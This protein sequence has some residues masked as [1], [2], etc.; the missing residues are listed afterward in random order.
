MEKTKKR[1][2]VV[3]KVVK[4]IVLVV[5][6]LLAAFVVVNV[7]LI[8]KSYINPNK[9]PDFFGFKPFIVLSGSMEPEI[10]AGDLVLTKT[11][12]P[13]EIKV[14]DVISFQAEDNIV[15]T[16]RVTEVKTDGGLS[17]LTKGDANVGQ[18][19]SSVTP[20]KIEGIYI[21]RAANLGRFALF[22]QTPMGMLLFVVTPMCLFILYDLIARNVRSRKTQKELAQTAEQSSTTD[23]TSTSKPVATVTA[24]KGEDD[25]TSS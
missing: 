12:D 11:I 22:I 13:K 23:Q 21:W 18:D 6:I 8:V 20:D 4:S 25:Q 10:M 15:V 5:C 7:T 17:F 3:S 16:H 1:S 14:G 2:S 19:G 24:I 9:V